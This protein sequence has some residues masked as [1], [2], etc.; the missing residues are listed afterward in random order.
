V[1]TPWEPTLGVC[2][3]GVFPAALANLCWSKVLACWTASGAAR[4]LFAVPAIAMA[5][6]A[7][8][9]GEI[10]GLMVCVGG[11]LALVGVALGRFRTA[12]A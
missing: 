7:W 10:P 11:V 12:S 8:L 4:S 6:V 2:Y 1:A 5:L 9:L 3:L